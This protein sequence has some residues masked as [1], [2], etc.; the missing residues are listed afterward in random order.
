SEKDRVMFNAALLESKRGHRLGDRKKSLPVAIAIHLATI[1]A[2]VGATM[3][4]TGEP[5]EPVIPVVFPVPAPPPPPLAM[6]GHATTPTHRDGNSHPVVAP[7]AQVH[8]ISPITTEPDVPSPEEPG[9]QEP[10]KA[11][12][13]GD[14]LGDP[15]GTGLQ[16]LAGSST[17]IGVAPIRVGGDVKPPVLLLRIDPEYP[18]SM[19]IGHK[20]GVVILE[21]VIA[22]TGDV[23]DIR[24][25]KSEGAVLD[26][27]ASEALRRWR[28]RPATL[29][30]R[31][32]SVYLTVTVTFGLRS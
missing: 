2:V 11:G 4:N 16:P 8:E 7:V 30:G 17:G 14:P 21:A 13:P 27:A 28:Y 3:W 29:N 23:D 15:D 5:P 6:G 1:G 19:R 22:A 25:L 9:L 24:V 32:V 12:P 10:E 20:Q 31:A 18:E 26:R